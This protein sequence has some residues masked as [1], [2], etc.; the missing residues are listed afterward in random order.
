MAPEPSL[1]IV[2][3]SAR[4]AAFSALRAGRQPWCLDLFADADLQARCHVEAIPPTEYPRSLPARVGA[5]PPGPWIYTG[6]LENHPAIVRRIA[7]DRPLLGHDADVLRRVRDPLRL[8]DLFQSAGVPHLV[9]RL[10]APSDGRVWLVKPLA[11]AGGAGVRVWKPGD[12]L[13]RKAYFQEFITGPSC[14][15]LYDGPRLL[16]VTEQLVGEPWLAA[17]QFH[18]CGS[19]GPL[20]L[21]EA[22]RTAFEHIGRALAGGCHLHGLFGVDFIQRDGV[23]LP[24]EVNPRYTASVEVLEYATRGIVGKAILFAR[25]PLTFP[26]DGPWLDTLRQ[27][28]PIHQ[29]PAFADIPAAGQPIAAGWPILT[30]FA[31]GESAPDCRRRLRECAVELERW[32][33]G[34]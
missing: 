19:I 18:Y 22:Q 10:T 14:A 6:G 11:G 3:A 1:I 16:G 13:P 8:A 21:T 34:E 26:A 27:P 24:V 33:Y 15:A 5:A 9:V 28:G 20:P 7:R 31:H 32:L 23:P 29:M 17:G 25:K 4:A 2:G 30:L 12:R